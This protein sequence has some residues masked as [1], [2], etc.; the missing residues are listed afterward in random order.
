MLENNPVQYIKEEVK[1]YEDWIRIATK[2]EIEDGMVEDWT[3]YL[4]DVNDLL[5]TL[6]RIKASA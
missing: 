4:K 5:N 6:K 2:D 3:G 1:R